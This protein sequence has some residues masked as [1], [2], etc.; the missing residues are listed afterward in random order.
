[1]S[2]EENKTIYQR[3]HE[4]VNQGNMQVLDA[5]ISPKVIYRD[6]ANPQIRGLEDYK[7]WLTGLRT[8]FPDAYFAIEDLIAERDKVACRFTFRGT[9]A[10]SWR[11]G[12]STGLAVAVSAIEIV[13]VAEGKIVEVWVNSDAM[14]LPQQ[15]GLVPSPGRAS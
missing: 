4:R 9:P 15:L 6:S 10:G 11:G 12:P 8:A 2:A 7:Q 1:M 13:R 5:F 3:A 14:G